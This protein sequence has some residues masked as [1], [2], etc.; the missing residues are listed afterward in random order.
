MITK[1]ITLVS[2]LL[3]TFSFLCGQ[4]EEDKILLLKIGDRKLKDKTMDIAAGK[5]YSARGGTQIPFQEMIKE[6]KE[7]EFIYVGETH[8]SLPMHDIQLKIIQALYE[9]DRNL[10]IGLEMFPVSFQEALNKWSMAILSQDEFIR[11]SRWYV[12]W[13]FNFGFYEKILRHAKN[14]KIPLYALNAPRTIISKIRMKGW[15]KLS[16]EEKKVVPNPDVSHEEH[17]TLIRTIFEATE[18]PHQMKGGGLD[19][20]FEGLYRA[21]SAWDEVMAFNA[22]RFR[23]R[24]GGKMVVLTGSGHLLYNLGVNRRAYEKS[25]LPFKTVICVVIPEGKKGIKVARSLADYVW[26]IPEEK[27]AAFPSIGLRFKKFDRLDN[28]VIESKP[29]DGVSKNA[30]F[31]KGDVVLSVDGKSYSDINELRIYLARIKWD[32]EVK[33]CILRNAQQLEVLLKFQPPEKKGQG[34]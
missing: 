31:E 24:E 14:N 5:I 28:L 1:K 34:S 23:E 18:L 13:N 11:E 4:E 17:R 25:H 29:I 8:N 22:L 30:N 9:Q 6:I 27:I 7:S 20:V 16:E 33:F 32:E 3:F 15:E 2:I 10:S 19:M 21:Q 12:N 26:G